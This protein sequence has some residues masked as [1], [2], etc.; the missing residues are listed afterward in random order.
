MNGARHC[1]SLPIVV[2]HLA[3]LLIGARYH[4][5][6]LIGRFQ[7]HPFQLHLYRA[8]SST[9]LMLGFRRKAAFYTRQLTILVS[10]GAQV[11]FNVRLA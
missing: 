9:Y 11:R 3:S 5:S 8:L 10:R 7:Q 4:A 1:A 2:R 6:P